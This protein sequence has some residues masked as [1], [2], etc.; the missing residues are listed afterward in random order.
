MLKRL[1][2]GLLLMVCGVP[3]CLA[4][5]TPT[6]QGTEFWVSFMRNGYRNLS[7]PDPETEK[8]VMIVSAKRGCT[9]TVRNPNQNWED[10]FTVGDNGVETFLVPDARGYNNQ[11]D[12]KSN[13]GLLVTSTDT[14]S[15]YVANEASDSYDAANVLPVQA[16][17]SNY[18][19][20]SSKSISDQSGHPDENRASFLVV[21][22]EDNTQVS[23][24]PTCETW[25]SHVA[26]RPYTVDLQAGECYHVLNK[27]QGT[28]F[29]PPGKVAFRTPCPLFHFLPPCT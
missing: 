21:A 9:V 7:E 17:G 16:L 24:T 2:C 18:M 26:G 28:T 3:M 8:L 10:S 11:Q 6:T 1:F 12:G 29:K 15:L 25:D 13:K 22:T 23:I 19:I 14:I 4:Q 20:Q 27:Y 5:Q